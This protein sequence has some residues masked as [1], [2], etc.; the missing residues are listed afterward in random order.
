MPGQ[1]TGLD[2]R[3]R[4]RRER[5]AAA[6]ARD[7][8]VIYARESPSNAVARAEEEGRETPF[9]TQIAECV[10]MA[11]QRKYDVVGEPLR[12]VVSRAEL[13][14][15]DVLDQAHRLIR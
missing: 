12:E 2:T 1:D 15:R 6:P 14:D 9:D 5:P 8:C 11:G 10:A 3:R 4:P 13:W 7:R